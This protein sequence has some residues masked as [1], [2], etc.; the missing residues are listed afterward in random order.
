MS[1]DKLR[2]AISS[3]V[4]RI[5]R[6]ERTNRGLSLN[7]LAARA[8]LSRQMVSYIEQEERNPSLDTMPLDVMIRRARTAG[9]KQ[10]DQMT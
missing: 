1:A 5:I 6:E 10:S 9:T 8:G 4:A 2:E 3:E 7:A